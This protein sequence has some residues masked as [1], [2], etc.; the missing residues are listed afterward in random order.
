MT[1]HFDQREKSLEID[2]MISRFGHV[3]R[4]QYIKICTEKCMEL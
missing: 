2:Y 4:Y 3:T 1:C